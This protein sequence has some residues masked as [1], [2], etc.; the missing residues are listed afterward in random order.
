MQEAQRLDALGL[1]ADAVGQAQALESAV[2]KLHTSWRRLGGLQERLWVES[3]SSTPYLRD[4]LSVLQSL[5]GPRCGFP[6]ANLPVGNGCVYSWLKSLRINW[7]PLW[8]PRSG[9]R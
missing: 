9:G 4:V 1:L 3:G 5:V 7:S 8:P 6:W 2:L